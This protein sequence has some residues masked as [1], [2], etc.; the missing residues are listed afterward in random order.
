MFLLRGNI[1]LSDYN[2]GA[3][4]LAEGKD[5]LAL[6]EEKSLYNFKLS[7]KNLGLTLNEIITI[8]GYNY[9]K[10]EKVKVFFVKG[11]IDDNS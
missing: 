1:I 8:N 4:F 7:A 3:I 10:G 6:I 2:E 5:N 9:S 11:F